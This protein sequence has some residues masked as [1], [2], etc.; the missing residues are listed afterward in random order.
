MLDDIELLERIG[1]GDRGVFDALVNKYQREIYFLALRMSKNIEDAEELTQQIFV[2][3]FEKLSGFRRD[4]SFKTW[5]YQLALN[6]CKSH[7]RNRH[8]TLELNEELEIP[9]DGDPSPLTRL[10]R[11]ETAA[12]AAAAIDSLPEKQRLT[13]TLRVFQEL[14]YSEI[15]KL[16]GCSEQTA[17]VNFHYGI[18][19]LRKKMI[20][21][22]KL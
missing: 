7:I 14:S 9:S 18:E 16:T 3:A 13:V 1:D 11:D 5:L 15:G 22:G 10:I 20:Q 12:A 21:N 8:D 2:K 17:K 19:N 6:H 4:A